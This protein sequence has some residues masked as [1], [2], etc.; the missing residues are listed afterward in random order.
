MNVRCFG[1]NSGRDRWHSKETQQSAEKRDAV[2]GTATQAR[3]CGQYRKQYSAHH[4]TPLEPT[5][6][7]AGLSNPAH[8]NVGRTSSDMSQLKT[9][10][11]DAD[12]L[13]IS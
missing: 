7:N 6:N 11:K 2:H 9:G 3:S 4:P 12:I 8:A 13:A 5:A 10:A 1:A